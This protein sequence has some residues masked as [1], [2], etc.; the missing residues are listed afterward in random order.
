[1][2]YKPPQLNDTIIKNGEQLGIVIYVGLHENN[3]WTA[4]I[5]LKDSSSV[6]LMLQ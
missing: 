5:K 6:L 4:H 3:I 2:K 1:M